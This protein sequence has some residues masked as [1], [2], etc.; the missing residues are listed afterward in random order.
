MVCIMVCIMDSQYPYQ[1][2]S[3]DRHSPEG[4]F[5]F[6]GRLP[7]NTIAVIAVSANLISSH[8]SQPS[9]P[10]LI[11]SHAHRLSLRVLLKYLLLRHAI[12][13][14]SSCCCFWQTAPPARSGHGICTEESTTR[15]IPAPSSLNVSP[16][17]CQTSLTSPH[18]THPEIRACTES[19]EGLLFLRSRLRLS[20]V[21]LP[22]AQRWRSQKL[23]TTA[24]SLQSHFRWQG[25]R[26]CQAITEEAELNINLDSHRHKM[27][28][29][30]LL[31][32]ST[33]TGRH[34]CIYDAGRGRSAS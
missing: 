3:Q 18:D 9:H 14:W 20:S 1:Q 32:A 12:I 28:S 34:P 8:P 27:S 30:P 21:R 19:Y 11:S 10:N 33:I 31:C 17:A 29:R 26:A 22:A 16:S 15:P 5:W 7:T 23:L 25:S 24:S 13:G 6:R 4:T 2:Y